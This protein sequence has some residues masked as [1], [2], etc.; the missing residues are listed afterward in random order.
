MQLKPGKSGPRFARV[1]PGWDRR[2]SPRP[3]FV[4]GV[5]P[6]EG[7]GPEI[8]AASLSLL[9]TIESTSGHRFEI[10]SGGK[11]GLEAQQASA[12]SSRRT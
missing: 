10:R 4:I 9:G 12:R 1:L 6:G 3:P 11:I 2:D 7:I 5:L 8:V